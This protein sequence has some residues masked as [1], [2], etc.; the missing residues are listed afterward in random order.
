L[1]V[2]GDAVRLTQVFAN[3]LSNAA[4][5]TEPRGNVS[6]AVERQE[7]QAVLRFADSG[8]GIAAE[9]L[10]RVFEMFF[11]GGRQASVTPDGLGI[12]LFLV[13]RLVALHGGTVEVA[14][15]PHGGSEFR[16][17]LP[18]VAAPAEQPSE[19][20]PVLSAAAGTAQA[21]RRILVVDDNRDAADSLSEV[22]RLTG[23]EVATGYD[24]DEAMALAET[25]RPDVVL[26]DLGLPKS[27]GYEVCRRL[28]AQPWAH[29]TQIIALT[30]W[31][32]QED[33][34][35]TKASGFAAHLVK[36]VNPIVL[37]KLLVSPVDGPSPKSPATPPDREDAT[38]GRMRKI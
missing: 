31:G 9:E 6:L 7:A 24:G 19:A 15:R 11:Q 14:N 18:L 34:V 23:N 13:K 36:P 30:G 1:W 8:V 35:R 3:L 27:D 16:V 25:F 21:A 4:K 5:F 22:L 12:G 33:S 10:S 17:C 2:D 20:A 29:G 28:K 26:L 37:E 32:R 38:T